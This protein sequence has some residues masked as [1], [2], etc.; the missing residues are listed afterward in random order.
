MRP[1]AIPLPTVL[2]GALSSLAAAL[3]VVLPR[4][5]GLD[6]AFGLAA[7]LSFFFVPAAVGA[8]LLLRRL[9]PRR[10]E[11]IRL[12]LLGLFLATT[13]LPSL[14]D[15]ARTRE[16][17]PVASDPR[18]PSAAP[19]APVVLI[20]LDG[21]DERL[22]ALGIEAG[23]LPTFAR[24]IR[25]GTSGALR[26][27]VPTESPALW[28]TVA[29]GH[30]PEIHGVE[31]YALTR[32][33][34]VGPPFGI[35]HPPP[36]PGWRLV[37]GLARRTG[38]AWADLVSSSQR[39][40]PAIWGLA[41]AC[42]ERVAVVHWWASW[43]AEAVNGWLVTDRLAY[44]RSLAREGIAPAERALTHPPGLAASLAPLVRDPALLPASLLAERSGLSEEETER[45]FRN[46]PADAEPARSELAFLAALDETY[47][48]VALRAA[49][50]L[51]DLDFLAVYLRGIDIAQHA[52]LAFDPRLV[53]GIPR[54]RARL[55]GEIVRRT[56]RWTDR[57]LADLLAR[58]PPDALVLVVSD[59]GVR[60]AVDED[61][62]VRFH[63]D[64]A[65]PGIL[66][67]RGPR[68][69][70]GARIEGASILDVAPTVLA[71]LGLPV[72]C[73]MPGR[74]WTELLGPGAS[75]ARVP[76]WRTL[77][78]P[79]ADP[80]PEPGVSAEAERRLRSLGYLR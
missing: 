24:L 40:V 41:S 37:R 52:A 7:Y 20:G 58:L 10:S 42:G 46:P 79:S 71:A 9:L 72:P 51:P 76:T 16:P 65:P 59:H 23:E 80:A 70:S 3:F 55:F 34:G 53:P 25:E 4:R 14:A 22:L 67:A 49:D 78:P 17:A 44:H 12:E 6:D 50:E 64:D 43:P 39:R 19:H 68:V 56:Y 21:A 45:F 60:R 48:A 35:S 61:G 18:S 27:L 77:R 38:L 57:W 63:H 32:F 29:T 5:G 33:A 26:T 66:L 28:T 13:L 36:V 1:R 30:P 31:E 11:W 15:V 73:E 8:G 75:V 74:A 47:G 62:S 54:E 69:P 2:A